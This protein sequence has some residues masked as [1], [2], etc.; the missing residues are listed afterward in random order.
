[1]IASKMKTD[2][3]STDPYG[4][5]RRRISAQRALKINV[6]MLFY[7]GDRHVASLLAMTEIDCHVVSRER[8][9]SQ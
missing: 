8:D 9:G 4:S 3:G 7:F 1:V 5:G 6:F 2:Q